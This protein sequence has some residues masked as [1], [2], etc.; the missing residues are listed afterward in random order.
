M[1]NQQTES[2]ARAHER[3]PRPYELPL[4][5]HYWRIVLASQMNVDNLVMQAW[6]RD[7]GQRVVQATEY[8]EQPGIVTTAA[9]TQ[10]AVPFQPNIEVNYN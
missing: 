2:G 6:Q 4:M 3:P 1:S 8:G 10:T 5:A 9:D 7:M